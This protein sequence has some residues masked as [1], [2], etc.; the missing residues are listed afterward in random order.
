MSNVREIVLDAKNWRG[1]DD[2]YD[3]FFQAV[4]APTWHGRN[5]N[6]LRDSISV[7]RI[8]TIEVPYLLR[9]NNFSSIWPGARSVAEDFV[10]LINEL[11]NSG[12]PVDIKTE[13]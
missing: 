7:G 11:H 1:P 2:L 8:N 3:S 12:C 13:D 6:A 4:G 9:I 10:R 5:F